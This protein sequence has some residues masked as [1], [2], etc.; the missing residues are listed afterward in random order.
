M[1]IIRGH[2]LARN[3]DIFIAAAECRVQTPRAAGR[4]RGRRKGGEL[5]AGA[6]LLP[7]STP[8]RPRRPR[9]RRRPQS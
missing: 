1:R 5:A 8:R 6:N 3:T 2:E 7:A 4:R 9:R